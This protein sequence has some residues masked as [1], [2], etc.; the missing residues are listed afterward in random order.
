MTNK[1]LRFGIPQN[2]AER[3]A[4]LWLMEHS[5]DEGENVMQS[6]AQAMRRYAEHRFGKLSVSEPHDGKALRRPHS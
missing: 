1:R 2:A 5:G 4:H 6:L 3:A